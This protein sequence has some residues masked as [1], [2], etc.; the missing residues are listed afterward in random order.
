MD[1]RPYTYASMDGTERG[2]SFSRR[3]AHQDAAEIARRTGKVMVLHEPGQSWQ[4]T[5]RGR[6][7][8]WTR[9]DLEDVA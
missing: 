6:R 8:M 9:I 5:P 3:R 7:A 2:S 1:A 4:I